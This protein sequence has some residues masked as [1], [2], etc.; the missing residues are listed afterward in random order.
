M[1]C[2]RDS[3]P[4]AIAGS[5][6]GMLGHKEFSMVLAHPFSSLC[7]SNGTLCLLWVWT[8][9]HVPSALAFHT[10]ALVYHLPPSMTHC[11]LDM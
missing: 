10:P 7:P 11:F 3:L 6:V 5:R 1:C 4:S 8:F 2:A 9:S